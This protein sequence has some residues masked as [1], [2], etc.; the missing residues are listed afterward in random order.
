M[1]RLRSAAK[2]RFEAARQPQAKAVSFPMGDLPSQILGPILLH[3]DADRNTLLSYRL[4][5]RQWNEVVSS[6]LEQKCL[7]PHREKG[8]N[9][10]SFPIIPVLNG[11]L[12]GKVIIAVPT[13]I[14]TSGGGNPFPSKS[15]VLCGKTPE[16]QP[17]VK[18]GGEGEQDVTQ[19][20]ALDVQLFLSK[21]GGFLSSLTLQNLP[22][23]LGTLTKVLNS[24][25]N[26][27]S[28]RL[29]D[30][31]VTD[32]LT[33]LTKTLPSLPRMEHLLDLQ[34]KFTKMNQNPVID[35]K[36]LRILQ[37]WLVAFYAGQLNRLEMEGIQLL[38]LKEEYVDK[39]LRFYLDS[40][41]IASLGDSPFQKLNELKIFRPSRKFFHLKF[42]FLARLSITELD[43]GR[44]VDILDVAKFIERCAES[45]QHLHLDVEWA[46]LI[47]KAYYPTDGEGRELGSEFKVD[48]VRDDAILNR[49]KIWVFR[50]KIP[51]RLKSIAVHVPKDQV[52]AAVLSRSLFPKFPA[53]EKITLL[54]FTKVAGPPPVDPVKALRYRKQVTE[55]FEKENYWSICRNLKSISVCS[56]GEFWGDIFVENIK[57]EM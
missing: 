51:Y 45:L 8:A 54:H 33:N 56:G 5:N 32:F 1:P 29:I 3:L 15:L 22:I 17:K 20:P 21:F 11:T 49:G 52:E 28:L 42:P 43:G 24:V 40:N 50:E 31:T 25:P 46:D 13:S 12:K 41:L 4:V 18:K 10:S 53:L 27:K 9:W 44:H 37:G 14:I 38:E 36:K 48:C 16:Q 2:A 39:S 57:N 19:P 7:S 30:I 34:L 47:E 6:I 26:L 55:F 23:S 35:R